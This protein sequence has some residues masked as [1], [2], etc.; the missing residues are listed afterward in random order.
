MTKVLL[1][2]RLLSAASAL[3]LLLCAAL[4]AQEP[5]TPPL[6]DQEKEEFLSRAKVLR[7]KELS[8]GVTNSERATLGDGKLTHDAHV[9]D[10]NISKAA[11]QTVQ[12]T[13]INFRD[14]YKFNIAAY[15]LDRLLGLNAVPVSVERQV[16]GSSAALTWWVDD[17][18]MMEKDRIKKK[19][20]PPSVQAWNDQMQQIRVFNELVYNTDANLGNLLITDD[21]KVWAVDFTRAFRLYKDL[22]APKNLTRIDRRVLN[23]LR[24]LN[25]VTLTDELGSYLTKPEIEGI[26][27]RR[28]AIV[29]QFEEKIGSAGE[30][31][32]VCDKPGH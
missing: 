30:G 27:A 31:A 23:G 8:V 6:T 3:G 7:R 14:S 11:F 22:K 4:A 13:E 29:K 12:G 2:I 10:V 19:M 28:D 18:Q 21:W 17:E 15:R 9:Q 1:K 16:A 24:A 25:E 5:S 26:L 32:V 20:E